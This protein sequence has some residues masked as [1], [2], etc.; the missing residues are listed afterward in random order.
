MEEY[1]DILD[2]HGNK[3]GQTKEKSQVHKD[4]DWHRSVHV[5]FLNSHRGGNYLCS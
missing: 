2:A 5:W 4:G 1:L 3:I